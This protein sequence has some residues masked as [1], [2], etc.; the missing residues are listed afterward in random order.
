MFFFGDTSH[1]CHFGLDLAAVGGRGGRREEDVD[2]EEEESGGRWEEHCLD[3]EVFPLLFSIFSFSFLESK[4]GVK[5]VVGKD[6]D[7][8]FFCLASSFFLDLE[9]FF[10]MFPFDF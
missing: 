1:R 5:V 7:F 6:L 8:H 3:L 2:E 9:V 4:G 10:L